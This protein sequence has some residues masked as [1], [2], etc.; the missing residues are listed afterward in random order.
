MN[1]NKTVLRLIIGLVWMGIG[2]FNLVRG[3][4]INA[5]IFIVVGIIF[6]VFNKGK[7]NSGMR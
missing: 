5:A 1:R 2:I 6:L 3:S 4:F 7:S